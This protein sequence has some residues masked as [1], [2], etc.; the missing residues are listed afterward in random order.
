MF[1]SK[2]PTESELPTSRQLLKSTAIALVVAGVVLVLGVLPA[3]YGIDITGAGKILGLTRMGDIKVSLAQENQVSKPQPTTETPALHS[4]QSD[5]IHFTLEPG[6]ATEYKLVMSKDARVEYYWSTENGLLNHDTHGDGPS[7]NFI[8]YKKD[9]MIKEDTGILIAAF[10]GSHGWYW[11]NR[12]AQTV[13][14]TLIV[15]GAYE[16]IKKVM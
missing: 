3:E 11:R 7:N 8:S 14:V 4:A 16:R 1:N 12:D 6:Q 13:S 2:Q 5:T 15:N 9:R 10:D